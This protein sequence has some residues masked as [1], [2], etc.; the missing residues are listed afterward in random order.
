MLLSVIVP[1][2][3]SRDTIEKCLVSIFDSGFTNF[4]V[5]VVDDYSNDNSVDL[6]KK[7]NVKI[8]RHECNLGPSAA[9]N[10]GAQYAKGK[11]LV[12]IDSDIEIFPDT[13]KKIVDFLTANKDFIAV[14]GY[15]SS[16]C[17]MPDILGRYK[18]LYMHC[19]YDQ[20]PKAVP[21]AFTSIF[22]IY[23]YVFE[24]IGGFNPQI[25]IIE[26]TLF[27]VVL[28]QAGYKL[29]FDSSIQV[30]HLHRYNL[31]KFITE[32]F[33]RSHNLFIH[34]LTNM[35]YRKRAPNKNILK[36]FTISIIILPFLLLSLLLL[37][38]NPWLAIL[39]L[40]VFFL[41]NLNFLRYLGN[42][43]GTIFALKS[44][45]ILILDIF[46]C[47]IAIIIGLLNFLRGKRI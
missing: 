1:M 17:E 22:A 18:N 19:S 42:H 25:R 4:E 29:G 10:T 37:F 21:W 33:K 28:N 2:Y 36:N 34:K 30:K 32:E 38:K 40:I 45:F 11:I 12:F 15:F 41:I 35:F 26:D 7:F 3:R 13:L 24:L 27:G 20:E 39:F 8:I 9:R 44:F 5:I 47:D 23:K 6:L 14:S 46:V 16:Q 43:Y 31:K